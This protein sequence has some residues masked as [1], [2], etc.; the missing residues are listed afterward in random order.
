METGGK[1]RKYSKKYNLKNKSIKLKIK[2]K[3]NKK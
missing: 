1:S 3:K 2:N